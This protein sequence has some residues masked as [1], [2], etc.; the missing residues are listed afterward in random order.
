MPSYIY[1]ALNGSYGMVY[2]DDSNKLDTD[3]DY[4]EVSLITGRCLQ[5]H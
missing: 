5:F 2:P 4:L 1:P 3:L